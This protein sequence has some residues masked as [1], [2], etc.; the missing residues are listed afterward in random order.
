MLK[1]KLVDG[2]KIRN[3]IDVDFSVIGGHEVYPYIDKGEI[4]FDRAF[5]KEREHFVKL[6]E[7]RTRL[8]KLYGYERAKEMLRTKVSPIGN[9]KL[10]KQEI[11]KLK[12]AKDVE[13]YLVNGA[14]VRKA[15]DPSFCFGGHY[16]VYKYVPKG[17]VW[18]DNA[19]SS[20]ERKYVIIHELHELNLMKKGMS[21][22]NAHDYACA[23]EKEARRNDGVGRYLKD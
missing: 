2:F 6:F 1:T 4:W 8:T 17:E 5:I 21:Y 12:G 15:F 13:V 16:L 9:K 14:L 7:E 23:A 18:I 20:Q 10:K 11:K 22:N 3:T 19:F